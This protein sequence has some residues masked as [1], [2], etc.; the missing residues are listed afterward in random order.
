MDKHDP[1]VAQ[2]ERVIMALAESTSHSTEEVRDVFEREYARLEGQARVRT[3]LNALTASNEAHICF[4]SR[5]ASSEPGS[6][7]LSRTSGGILKQT[8]LLTTVEPPTQLPCR[9]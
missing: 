8:A 4:G 1:D 6:F 2:R 9:T 3:H 7:H 5:R